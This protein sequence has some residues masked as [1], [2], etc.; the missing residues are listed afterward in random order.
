MLKRCFDV[1]FAFWGILLTSPIFALVAAAIKLCDGGPVFYRQVR[2][3]R[4]GR[5]FRIWKFRT[6]QVDADKRGPNITKSG[7]I[8]VTSVGKFLRNWKVDEWPQLVNVL[9]GEMSFV[10][11]RPEVPRYVALYSDQQRRILMLRPGI[12]DLATI[13]FRNEED[14]LAQAADPERYYCDICIP[15]K[16]ALNLVHAERAGFFADLKIILRTVRVVIWP[17]RPQ[18]S[19]DAK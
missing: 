19:R 18:L 15:R 12:T 10:G 14:L 17:A 4:A 7:D 6:M 13:E 5:N 16:I 9:C 2:V 11:P 8:R 3:G 1:F